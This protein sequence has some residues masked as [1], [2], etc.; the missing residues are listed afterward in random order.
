M[1][2]TP[3]C[4][5]FQS[6]RLLSPQNRR[7]GDLLWSLATKSTF[8]LDLEFANSGLGSAYALTCWLRRLAEI[9]LYLTK[10]SRWRGANDSTRGACAP[11]EK[12]RHS[13]A[14]RYK[15]EF[16]RAQYSRGPG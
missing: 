14:L 16:R 15:M 9:L 6:R 12:R 3:A 8:S 13:A 10:E 4:S 1:L 11:P 5:T 7:D 2:N